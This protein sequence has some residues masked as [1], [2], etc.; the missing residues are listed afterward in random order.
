MKETSTVCGLSPPEFRELQESIQQFEKDREE[1]DLH[2]PLWVRRLSPDE[3][4]VLESAMTTGFLDLKP[5]A[6]RRPHNESEASGPATG[7]G[8]RQWHLVRAFNLFCLHQDRRSVVL[9]PPGPGLE[10]LFRSLIVHCERRKFRSIVAELKC[11]LDWEFYECS[12]ENGVISAFVST[13][14]A[15]SAAQKA[16]G[17]LWVSASPQ[18]EAFEMESRQ[19]ST[20][21]GEISG[22]A[23]ETISRLL[24]DQ[25]VWE[26]RALKVAVFLELSREKHTRRNE[27]TRLVVNRPWLQARFEVVTDGNVD[28]LGRQRVKSLIQAIRA[29]DKS[30]W[31]VLDPKRKE[32]RS[33]NGFQPGSEKVM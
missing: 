17:L 19:S 25:P 28:V 20:K 12:E 7:L 6:L 30:P 2:F 14:K 32:K 31:R 21:F 33:T 9:M 23:Y 18:K 3:V 11:E 1:A 5:V 29:G 15:V 16:T 26:G 22:L 4:V 8:P 10:S 24:T 27:A 13:D